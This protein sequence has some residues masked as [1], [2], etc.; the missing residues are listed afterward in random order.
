MV[1]HLR[2]DDAN[3]CGVSLKDDVELVERLKNKGEEQEISLHL[4]T[5]KV[6]RTTLHT[7]QA[8]TI[9][10]TSEIPELRRPLLQETPHTLQET[11]PPSTCVLQQIQ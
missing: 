4:K 9:L 1:I 3:L 2:K 7:S 6:I 11:Q 10:V 8:V 5:G